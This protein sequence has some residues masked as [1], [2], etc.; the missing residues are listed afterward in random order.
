MRLG[1][2][3]SQINYL[4]ALVES[5]TKPQSIEADLLVSLFL[6][7]RPR[8]LISVINTN[9]RISRVKSADSGQT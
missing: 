8:F 7:W 6:M 4:K 3:Q 9:D 2:D 1:L 5:S